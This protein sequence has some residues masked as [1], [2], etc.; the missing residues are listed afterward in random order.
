MADPLNLGA[1]ETVV[2]IVAVS[3]SEAFMRGLSAVAPRLIVDPA[4]SPDAFAAGILRSH[5][6]GA[7]SALFAH[8]PREQHAALA[9]A[10]GAFIASELQREAGAHA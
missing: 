8:A 4:I 3:A 10:A 5:L 1:D 2:A 9:R 7:M 6:L